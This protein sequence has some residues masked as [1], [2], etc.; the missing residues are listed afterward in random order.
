M[1]KWVF[2]ARPE[3]NVQVLN[4]T[5]PTFFPLNSSRTSS[6]NPVA[7]IAR[8]TL[9]QA[10][11]DSS[12][13]S[14]ILFNAA[15]IN[16][17]QVPRL[18][19]TG[20]LA[21]FRT[22][23]AISFLTQ[24]FQGEKL[25]II[26]GLVKKESFTF[27]RLRELDDLSDSLKN[28]EQTVTRLLGEGTLNPKSASSSRFRE[29]L[30][31]AGK[32]GPLDSFNVRPV[33]LSR[34]AE[35]ASDVKDP[36]EKLGL[37]G[38]F[39]VNGVEVTVEATDSLVT[40]RNKI[41]FGEDVNRNGSLDL[42]EDVNQNGILEILQVANSESGPGVFI[43]E[44]LN[45]DGVIDSSEDTNSN[46]R[47]DG[48]TLDNKVLALVRGNRL[49]LV[50]LTG[51]SNTIDLKDD[52]DVLLSLGFF[53]LNN[54]GLSVQKE[55]Q[56]NDLKTPENL[57][58]QPQ[59]SIAEVDGKFFASDTD[60]VSGVI[61][62]TALILRQASENSAKITIFID[63][64]TF[65]AQIKNLF[66]QF[67]DSISKINDLLSVSKTFE[68]DGDIQDIRNELTIEPQKRARGLEERNR[69]IDD[70]RGRP[71][72]PQATGISVVN[73][74][75]GNPQEVAVTSI[76]KAIQTGMTFPVQNSDENLLK[77]LSSIGIRTLTDNTF[78][79][80]ETEFERGL[81]KNTQEV[82][83]LFTNSETGILP[84]LAEQLSII[85][86]DELGDLA[87]KKDKVVIQSGAPNILA[88][89]F[90]KFTENSNLESTFQT[91]IAVA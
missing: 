39:L 32:N 46:E 76:V 64:P 20:P 62:D 60:V 44:D 61:E 30:A 54:K 80:D 1:V 68:S 52:D 23:D 55:F 47:L 75:K 17:R 74:E 73:A 53:E 12:N 16:K 88:Q 6:K 19:A 9:N 35:L 34:T 18:Q 37:T 45:D 7:N 2:F 77:R 65:F 5:A 29:V 82:F 89:N 24:R 43:K 41:N 26:E 87:L 36:S 83:D 25:P 48:G 3:K 79:L 56:F 63:A 10:G 78:A 4:N 33:R 22:A 91:L 72:N 42:T 81:E 8:D 69:I 40:I 21:T 38:S 66:N 31:S 85:V 57:V 49:V 71:G 58:V 50:S 51:G 28:L 67:N 11:Q 14:Q 90:R 86:R 27:A 15:F 59:T 13:S 70:F 84:V